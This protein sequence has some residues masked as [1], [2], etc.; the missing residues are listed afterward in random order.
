MTEPAHPG[1]QI[2]QAS[3]ECLECA[4]EN[5][6]NNH[7]GMLMR[8]TQALSATGVIAALFAGAIDDDHARLIH[9]ARAAI[10]EERGIC[11]VNGGIRRL[12]ACWGNRLRQR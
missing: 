11:D 6:D 4:C 2:P 3:T 5:P 1:L 7:A 12:E 9:L 10:T 8:V